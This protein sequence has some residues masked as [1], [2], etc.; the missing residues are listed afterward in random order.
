[1]SNNASLEGVKQMNDMVIHYTSFSLLE[2]VVFI[3]AAALVLLIIMFI[4]YKWGPEEKKQ[5]EDY[6]D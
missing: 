5:K 4:L 2:V 6:N 3:G 1:M